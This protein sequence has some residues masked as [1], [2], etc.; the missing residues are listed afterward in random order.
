MSERELAMRARQC[1]RILHA[2]P[3]ARVNNMD[4]T[5]L[6]YVNATRAVP[7]EALRPM[8]DALISAGGEWLPPAGEVVKRAA[9]A[10]SQARPRSYSP[11]SSIT[12]R[13]NQ[14]AALVAAEVRRATRSAPPLLAL[15]TG[16]QR[17]L[18]DGS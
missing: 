1:A 18:G 12:E 3:A 2:W 6:E 10:L 5:L 7:L 13:E 15:P 11:A 9:L 4:H 8:V 14:E 17:R 16:A